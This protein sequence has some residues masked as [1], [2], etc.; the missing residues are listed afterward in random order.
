MA[1]ALIY[2]HENSMIRVIRSLSEYK[3]NHAK[4]LHSS[5]IAGPAIFSIITPVDT[6]YITSCQNSFHLS[7]PNLGS[8]VLIFPPTCDQTKTTHS[9]QFH[10]NNFNRCWWTKFHVDESFFFNHWVWPSTRDKQLGIFLCISVQV[11]AQS[12]AKALLQQPGFFSNTRN[13]AKNC[14]T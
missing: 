12:H 11:T 1:W 10:F 13:G 7:V 3:Q 8:Q 2:E 6:E 4:M 14:V 5:K 9:N